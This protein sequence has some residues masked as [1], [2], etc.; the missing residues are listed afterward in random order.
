MPSQNIV[1]KKKKNFSPRIA[2]ET[3]TAEPNSLCVSTKLANKH[4]FVSLYHFELLFYFRAY[5]DA[6]VRRANQIAESEI[7]NL[8]PDHGPA[9]KSPQCHLTLYIKFVHTWY[10]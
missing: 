8:D 10:F 4:D 2:R 3:P 7:L 9:N 6:A 1:K 5:C